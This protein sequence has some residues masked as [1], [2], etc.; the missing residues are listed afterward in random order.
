[1]ISKILS[2]FKNKLKQEEAPPKHIV[3][4]D[5]SFLE[6]L[7]SQ[8]VIQVNPEGD[9]VISFDAQD[10]N[11]DYVSAIG[12]LIFLINSGALSTFF[13]KSLELWV[14]EVEGKER[15]ERETFV[16]LILAQ[17]TDTQEEHQE[18]LDQIQKS[19]QKNSS[20]SAVDPSR[21]F[22]LRKYL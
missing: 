10:S 16:A 11:L 8:I 19:G 1:M 14:E 18:M 21:V 9:F 20:Q 2:M 12:N 5:Y 6:G 4:G 17:W 15:D 22:N 13:I 7:C 3:Q